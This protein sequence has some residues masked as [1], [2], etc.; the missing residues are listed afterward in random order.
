M[1][2]CGCNLSSESK[3][4]GERGH[5]C[6]QLSSVLTGEC[7]GRVGSGLTAKP[8]GNGASLPSLCSPHLPLGSC[9]SELP[10][11]DPPKVQLFPMA[12]AT[13]RGR[14]GDRGHVKM[15]GT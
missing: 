7:P 14:E 12:Y 1:Y 13:L 2:T 5:P 9:D 8:R 10:D 3:C 11:P 15:P 4:E 6:H